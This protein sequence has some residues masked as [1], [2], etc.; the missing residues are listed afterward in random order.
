MVGEGGEVDN[1]GDVTTAAEEWEGRGDGVR[2]RGFS[3]LFRCAV[4]NGGE[5]GAVAG[6][7]GLVLD[8]GRFARRLVPSLATLCQLVFAETRKL[9]D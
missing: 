1:P 7:F 4:E 2:G 8:L 6:V 3:L 9:E 5:L